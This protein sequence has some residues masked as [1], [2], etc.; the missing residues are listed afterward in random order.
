MK[1][2]HDIFAQTRLLAG[3]SEQS[4]GITRVYLSAEHKLAGIT[5]LRLMHAAGMDA[6]WDALGNVVGRYAADSPNAKVLMLGSHM[7]SVRNAGAYDGTFGILSAIACVGELSRKKQRLDVT[8]EVIA[9]A[10]EEGVRFGATLI[11]SRAFAGKFDPAWLETVDTNGISMAQ[12]LRDFG[13]SVGVEMPGT[14][15]SAQAL[16]RDP[17]NVLAYVESHIEQG[18]VLLDRGLSVGAVTAIAGATRM[19]VGVRGLAGHAGTV[20]MPLRRDA[21]AGAAAMCVAIEAYA[22]TASGDTT[23]AAPVVATVGKFEVASGGAVNVIPGE[24]HFTID[25]RSGNDTE[26]NKAVAAIHQGCMVG[27]KKRNLQI[28]F[29]VFYDNPAAAC[30]AAILK[31]LQAAIAQCGQ[32]AFTLPSGAGHDAMA[33]DGVLPQAMLFVRCGNGGI[34]H[35]PDEIMTMEDAEIATEVLLRFLQSYSAS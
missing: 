32:P 2:A 9:F 27:A 12:A 28:S 18:P 35:H 23:A 20:P 25:V 5:I 16:K 10:D 33:F 14:L 3:F 30:N 21:L 15:A 8:L 26:R 31:G 6:H 11:G 7:D 17:A 24:V 22:V 19:R 1:F 4:N 13:V 34:S 29:D